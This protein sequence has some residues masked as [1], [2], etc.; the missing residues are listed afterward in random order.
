MEKIGSQ[1]ID[2]KP[3]NIDV[4]E[5]PKVEEQPVVETP[6]EQK[7]EEK[8]KES[9]TSSLKIEDYYPMKENTRY[10]YE[11]TGNEY[12]SYNVMIDYVKEGKVQQR[13]D[14]GG[15]MMVNIIELT[16]GKLIRT[17]SRGEAYYR[18]NLLE[19]E[20]GEE[21]ILLMEPLKEGTASEV[22]KKMH[23]LEQSPILQ[24]MYPHL[25]GIIKQLRLILKGPMDKRWIIMLKI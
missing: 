4:Q 2:N 17:Y 25:M 20:S 14:N 21:E 6:K 9:V 5:N 7:V 11:G 8:D 3:N 23:A 15:T 13:I 19:S 12:A 10:V 1:D 18:E 22:W 24:Q 16:N